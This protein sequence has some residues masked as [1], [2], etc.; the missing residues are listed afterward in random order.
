MNA[1]TSPAAVGGIEELRGLLQELPGP[2]ETAADAARTREPQ[3]TKP[4]GSLGRL[5]AIAEWL[6]AWQGRHPP[7]LS[8][9]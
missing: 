3:L 4:P 8:S 6:A 2:D 7:E 5:E 1:T 9:V